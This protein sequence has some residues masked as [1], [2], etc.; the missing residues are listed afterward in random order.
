MRRT[1]RSLLVAA[2]TVVSVLPAVPA[3]GAVATSAATPPA[4]V[5]SA[6]PVIEK[7]ATPS[8]GGRHDCA[9]CASAWPSWPKRANRA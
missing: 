8:A 4:S 7:P 5:Q 2:L 9:G 3:H 1:R 6:T